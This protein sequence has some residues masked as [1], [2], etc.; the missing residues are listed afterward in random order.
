M[1]FI[2]IKQLLSTGAY[3]SKIYRETTFT[4]ENETDSEFEPE[5]CNT[6]TPTTHYGITNPGWLVRHYRHRYIYLDR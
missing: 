3:N 6:I 4:R 5:S 1:H 2:Y